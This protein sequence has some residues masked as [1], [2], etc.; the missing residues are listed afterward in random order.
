MGEAAIAAPI[1]AF[2]GLISTLLRGSNQLWTIGQFPGLDIPSD[3]RHQAEEIKIIDIHKNTILF[4]IASF[5]HMNAACRGVLL[6]CA[7]ILDH[8]TPRV[9]SWLSILADGC[10]FNG[11]LCDCGSTIGIRF[12]E[13]L[14]LVK[15]EGVNAKGCAAECIGKELRREIG[16]YTDGV[17]AG[18]AGVVLENDSNART[19]AGSV[20]LLFSLRV[21]VRIELNR[22]NL[23]LVIELAK[24]FVGHIQRNL[25]LNSLRF[26]LIYLP[27]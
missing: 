18:A 1:Y 20:G 17:A 4:Q 9:I 2:L 3:L 6:D 11:D 22:R 14:F 24:L 16:S 5:F 26:H 27:S 12:A 10:T 23:Q 21:D 19:V 25:I 7:T 8:D 15:F 13:N